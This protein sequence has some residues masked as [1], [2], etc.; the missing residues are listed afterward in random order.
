HPNIPRAI[1]EVDGPWRS[2]YPRSMLPF[3][4]L[5][6]QSGHPIADPAKR[7]VE[8][9]VGRV[10]DTRLFAAMDVEGFTKDDRT[11]KILL[12]ALGARS[13]SARSRSVSG[14]SKSSRTRRRK[15]TSPTRSGA[16]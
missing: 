9:T 10:A 2:D 15:S 13:S 11:A 7:V 4:A 1:R 3:L 6:L 12:K 16:T 14:C 8:S 5:L